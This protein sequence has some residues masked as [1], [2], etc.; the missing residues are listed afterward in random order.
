MT[1]PTESLEQ[2]LED[3]LYAIDAE[4]IENDEALDD[5]IKEKAKKK[6]RERAEAISLAIQEYIEAK[7]TQYGVERSE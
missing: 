2:L 1:L 6:I 4:S 5:D 3:N 7:L